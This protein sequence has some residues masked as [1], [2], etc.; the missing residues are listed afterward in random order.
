[1]DTLESYR[2]IVE[3]ILAEYA[4]IPYAYGEINYRSRL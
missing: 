1:M 4:A 2:Q 3:Q